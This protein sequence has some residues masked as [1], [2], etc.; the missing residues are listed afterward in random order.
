MRVAM[1][2]LKACAWLAILMGPGSSSGFYGL[3]I[4]QE[5]ARTSV[6]AYDIPA[7]PLADGLVAYEEQTEA[8]IRFDQAIVRDKTNQAVHG[9]YRPEA[10][11]RSMLR[12]TG[13]TFTLRADG[14]FEIIAAPHSAGAEKPD[15]TASGGN[16]QV[17]TH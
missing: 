17:H 8:R 16:P 12:G 11:L 7:Q 1:K 5:D 14:E 2:L 13:L 6:R 10:A 9:G 15:V 3:A 4:A